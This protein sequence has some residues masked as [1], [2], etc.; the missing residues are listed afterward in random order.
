M[1]I[2]HCEKGIVLRLVATGRRRPMRTI[3]LFYCSGNV[4]DRPSS[5][6]ATQSR[7]AM[8]DRLRDECRSRPRNL[9]QM[10][11]RHAVLRHRYLSDSVERAGP[12]CAT[13]T[14]TPPENC[15]R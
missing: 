4:I 11:K 6:H 7:G 12:A 13:Q 3:Y 2:L 15:R 5:F 8:A 14:A 9:P 1:V 10:T